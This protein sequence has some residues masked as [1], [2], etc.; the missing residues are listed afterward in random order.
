LG[1]ADLEALAAEIAAAAGGVDGVVITQGTDTIEETAFVLDRLVPSS[2]PV[3]VTGAMR[4]PT[5]AGADGPANLLAA[6]QVA[7]SAQ[8]R[9]LGCLVV[10]NDEIH[11]ARFVRKLHTSST[12][13]F[14][15]GPAGQLGWLAEG[16]VRLVCRLD[17]MPGLHVAAQPRDVKVALLTMALGDDGAL[18]DA[19]AGAGIDGLVV[20]GM[21]GGHVPPSVADALERAARRLPVVLAS[22]AG[23]GEVLA[24][25]YGFPGGEIDL[26][27]RGLIRA[28]WLDGI[29]AKALLTLMLRHGS[30]SRDEIV[31]IFEAWGGGAA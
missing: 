2:M 25:T 21:G 12:A 26:Q 17:A 13:A 28:G 7:A 16:A 6:V 14:S 4:N 20:A 19:V 10:M 3:V 5:L 27:R 11:A 9:G 31:H 18:V 30:A 1:Y 15:S 24:R 8:T 23:A 22:R 29:K